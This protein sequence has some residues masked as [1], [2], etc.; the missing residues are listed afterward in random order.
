MN[1][2]LWSLSL[3]DYFTK[4]MLGFAFAP[5]IAT[6]IAFMIF[7]SPVYHTLMDNDNSSTIQIETSQ[8]TFQDGSSNTETSHIIYEG[9][10]GFLDFM[11]NN[12]VVSWIILTF[13]FFLLAMIMFIIAMVTAIIIIGFLTPAI[14]RELQKR[15]YPEIAL[16]EHGNF[17]TG[18]FSSMKYVV[19]MFLL[20][21]VMIPLYFIPFVNIV[22][23]NLPFYYLF[24]KFYMLDVG[25]SAMS[26]EQFKQMM[27]FQGNRVRA[28]SLALYLLSMIP[29]AALFTPVFN[30]IVLGHIALSSRRDQLKA[31]LNN[32]ASK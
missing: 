21:I 14:M 12:G 28:N 26:K 27:Y 20:L 22:A 25:T 4:K 18:I 29:F 2:N 32:D 1:P 24:H 15:H 8:T 5:F 31:P 30:V 17:I 19:V 3:S 6:L 9:D 23:V 10:N 11:L 7:L 16:E 13:S